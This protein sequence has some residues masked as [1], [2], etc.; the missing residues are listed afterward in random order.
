MGA[1]EYKSAGSGGLKLKGVK[2]SRVEKKHKKKKYKESEDPTA[3]KRDLAGDQDP[4]EALKDKD[5]DAGAG[6]DDR[7]KL[8]SESGGENIRKTEAERKHED[9][10]R[11]RVSVC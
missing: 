6:S 1:N 5:A 3:E 2:D 7:P 10:R 9:M 8:A 4:P 11:K